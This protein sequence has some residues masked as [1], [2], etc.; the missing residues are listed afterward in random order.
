M[1]FSL[2]QSSHEGNIRFVA[3]AEQYGKILVKLDALKA[4][5]LVASDAQG[6]AK[7]KLN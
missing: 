1:Q 2:Y 6:N 4:I 5:H 7:E 3:R